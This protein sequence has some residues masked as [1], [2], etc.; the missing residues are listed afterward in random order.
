MTF[1]VVIAD[2][3][4]RDATGRSIDGDRDGRPGGG[5]VVDPSGRPAPGP[6]PLPGS[7]PIIRLA[8]SMRP[9]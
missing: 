8:Y 3:A 6:S 1:R 5:F 9:S 2:G 4:L 7:R